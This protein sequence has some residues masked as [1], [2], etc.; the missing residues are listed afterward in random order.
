MVRS[1]N[2]LRVERRGLGEEAWLLPHQS[3][4]ELQDFTQTGQ[5][6]HCSQLLTLEQLTFHSG[7]SPNVFAG[8]IKLK[9]PEL[10]INM[11]TAIKMPHLNPCLMFGVWQ[12]A[13]PMV[14]QGKSAQEV[15]TPRVV[16]VEVIDIL[17]NNLAKLLI[18]ALMLNLNLHKCFCVFTDH[19]FACLKN[20]KNYLYQSL[21]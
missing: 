19:A 20:M 14:E 10:S 17:S 11:N 21:I 15:A 18:L 7:N 8:K 5:F 12:D 2:H 13:M 9:L 3:R 4:E 1:Q 16:E 6:S